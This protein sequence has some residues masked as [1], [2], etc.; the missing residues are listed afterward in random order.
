MG[1]KHRDNKK[2]YEAKAQKSKQVR[3]CAQFFQQGFPIFL[4]T[5]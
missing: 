5:A 4:G 1:F 3:S 2:G